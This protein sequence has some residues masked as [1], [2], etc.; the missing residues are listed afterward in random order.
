[1][2]INEKQCW[3]RGKFLLDV[4]IGDWIIHINLPK[5]G[6]CIVG[7]VLETYS[8]E[9]EGNEV[10]D[11][12]HMIKLDLSTITAFERND[13]KVLPI[14]QSRLKLQGSHWRIFPEYEKD[15]L[16]TIDNLKTENFG[17]ETSENVGLFYFKKDLQ[18]LLKSIT[19]KIQHTHPASKL[20]DL[21]AMVFRKIPGIIEV[22]ENGKTKGWRTDNGADLIIKYKSGLSISSLE[23]EETLVVQIKS[24]TGH[25][26]ETTAVAQIETAINIYG[27]NAGLI[28]TTAETTKGLEDAIEELSNKLEK[29]IGLIAGEDV[30][31]FVLKYGSDFIL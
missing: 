24:Y 19:Q 30:A 21:I 2:T 12:R 1:M 26:W 25:H 18:P 14:I 29:P 31:R 5:W 28:I 15:F 16:E 11:F 4:A 8:F 17:K 3:K 7:R 13:P 22:K 20:E 27:A 9:Q 10:G 23:K 6:S